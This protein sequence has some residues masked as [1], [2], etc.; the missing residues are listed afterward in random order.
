M[1]LFQHCFRRF[2]SCRIY[3]NILETIGNTPIV[4]INKLGP[5]NINLYVKCEYFNPLSSIKDRMAM[6]IICNAECNGLLLPNQTVIEATSGNAGI[7]LAL[8]CAVK[9]YPFIAVTSDC[10]SIERRKIMRAL[11]AKVI[12]IPS[13]YGGQGMHAKA[14]ELSKQNKWFLAS[15]AENPANTE[16]H[17][18]TTAPEILLSFKLSN[19][20]LDYFVTGYGSGG[21]FTGTSKI[22]KAA[23]PNIKIILTEPTESPLIASGIKQERENEGMFKGGASKIHDSWNP[24]SITGWAPSFIPQLAQDG[25]DLNLVDELSTIDSQIAMQT[26]LDLAQNE[27]IFTGISGGATFASALKICNKVSDG[28]NILAMLPDT[29]ERY[30]STELFDNI[31]NDMNDD[32]IRI[33]KST[34]NYL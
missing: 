34:P 3:N 4:A 8:V 32:E 16:Y 9:G 18:N 15:Q 21:T 10:F 27:G 29:M 12:L 26:S 17:S 14:K 13:K 11:G 28:S 25:I 33:A 19:K 23:N 7:G 6:G 30:L 24:H 2:S 1:T 20:N 22:L 5:S 31:Q